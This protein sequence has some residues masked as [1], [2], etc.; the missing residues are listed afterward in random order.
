MTPAAAAEALA[1][2]K[3]RGDDADKLLAAWA[4][5]D[6]RVLKPL[7][8]GKVTA[9][10]ALGGILFRGGPVGGGGGG[11]AGG[12]REEEEDDESEPLA[13]AS[14]SQPAPAAAAAT[15]AAAAA[16]DSSPLIFND[17]QFAGIAEPGLYVPPG[18][19]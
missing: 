10:T 5:L 13:R 7:F 8:G 3:A 9:A 15:T 1:A 4:Q 19:L 6:S 2:A 16:S 12:A 17:E 14:F 11:G 18:G